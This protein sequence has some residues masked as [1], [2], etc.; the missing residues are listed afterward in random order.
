MVGY[1]EA[2]NLLGRKTI[3]AT[4]KYAR[5]TNNGTFAVTPVV[6]NKSAAI[7]PPLT[8]AKLTTTS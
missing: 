3:S 6:G 5:A 8:I 1:A 7:N 2:L 4:S